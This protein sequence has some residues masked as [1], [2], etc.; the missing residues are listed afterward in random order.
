[1]ADSLCLTPDE[2][3]ETTG[4]V[5]RKKQLAWFL[6]RGIPAQLGEDGRVKVL[7]AAL[8]AKMM[9]VGAKLR[10]KTEPRLDLA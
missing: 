8:H 1:M 5:R 7:R 2:V 4:A 10:A 9:P 6:C 3:A